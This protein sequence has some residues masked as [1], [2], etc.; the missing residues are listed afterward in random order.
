MKPDG[1][2]NC[3]ATIVRTQNWVQQAISP[4]ELADPHFVALG[5]YKG[6]MAFHAT[7]QTLARDALVKVLERY[8]SSTG[9]FHPRDARTVGQALIHH[10]S[11]RGSNMYV[12]AFQA[13]LD[14]A[15]NYRNAW[16]AWGA[17][18]AGARQLSA[19]GLE[20]LEKAI[21]PRLGAIPHSC[22]PNVQQPIFDLGTNASCVNALLACG[23]INA[24]LRVGAFIKSIIMAQSAEAATVS[25]ARNA[26]GQLVTPAEIAS[27]VARKLYLFS[28]GSS[29]QI[30]WP[31]GFALK[32]L[33]QLYKQ[34]G[35]STWLAPARRISAWLK[36]CPDEHFTSITSAKI[37]WG[38]GAMF[39]ETGEREWAD[40]TIRA[41]NAIISTQTEKGIWIRP[42]LPAWLPQPLLV[43]A[44]T[45]LER[46]YYLTQLPSAL[47]KPL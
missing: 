41:T 7:G 19:V 5:L 42:D 13:P 6:L 9:D 4:G 47:H 29:G 24:A 46:M 44:D 45:S 26:Q 15:R 36:R 3:T 20:G 40:L 16:F 25:L 33:A 27:G 1:Y 10:R 21:H 39:E 14:L 28:P 11:H 31:L 8:V 43:S 18:V 2:Q 30:Y 23:R 35:D 22:A 38:A 32:V 17:H 12:A 37:C 34:T